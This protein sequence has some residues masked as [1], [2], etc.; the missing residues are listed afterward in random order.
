MAMFLPARVMIAPFMWSSL[1]NALI[2]QRFPVCQRPRAHLAQNALER[3][4]VPTVCLLERLRKRNPNACISPD[5][6]AC[7]VC[8]M[9]GSAECGAN[10]RGCCG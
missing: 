4:G 10:A 7:P 6:A 5:V 3:A 8:S 1:T 2:A 9:A